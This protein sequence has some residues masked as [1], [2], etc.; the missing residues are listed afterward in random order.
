MISSARITIVCPILNA[1]SATLYR[2]IDSLESQTFKEW[3][4]IFINGNNPDSPQSKYLLELS[5]S[6]HNI[7]VYPEKK[8]SSI[9]AAMEYGYYLKGNMSWTL[10][11]GADDYCFSNSAFSQVFSYIDNC[12]I[13]TPI[14]FS[15]RFVSPYNDPLRIV[16]FPSFLPTRL[17]FF[18]GFSPAHQ[19]VLLPPNFKS[20]STLYQPQYK[21]A[22]DLDFFLRINN[23]SYI[24][25]NNKICLSCVQCDGLS[26][27]NYKKKYREVH[28]IYF[29][30]FSFLFPIPL[31]FRYAS[32]SFSSIIFKFLL[33]M[34]RLM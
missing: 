30:H 14:F 23:A 11:W 4:L 33:L 12:N 13:S 1:S 17:S 29:E 27:R 16:N 25:V 21:I 18:L 26:T 19:S 24:T 15:A 32:K 8:P 10:F 3:C 34:S 31:F 5:S 9:Y 6:S 20:L 28:L 7:F 22:A 2:L